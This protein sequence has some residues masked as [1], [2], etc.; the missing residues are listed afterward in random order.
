MGEPRRTTAPRY[1][2]GARAGAA[3]FETRAQEAMADS[4][5]W[6]GHLRDDGD[7]LQ[8][9][10][11]GRCKLHPHNTPRFVPTASPPPPLEA[12]RRPPPPPPP[13]GFARRGAAVDRRGGAAPHPPPP[14]R[15]AA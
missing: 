14:R 2:Q 7:R 11:A 6:R 10:A 9:V 12:P 8:R 13:A 3:S 15:R 1:P 4:Q 5:G